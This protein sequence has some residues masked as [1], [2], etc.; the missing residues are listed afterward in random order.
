[1]RYILLKNK[2]M[3]PIH[4][5]EMIYYNISSFVAMRS[6][7]ISLKA[8]IFLYIL[9][10]LSVTSKSQCTNSTKFPSSNIQASIFN[11]LQTITTKQNAG[12]YFIIQGLAVGQTYQ[13]ESSNAGVYITVRDKDR[14]LL[15]GHGNTPFSYTVV[16]DDIVSVHINLV[17]PNCGS[18]NID[19]LTT[20]LCTTCPPAPP[21]IGI[22][23]STPKSSLDVNGKL[24]LNDNEDI[25]AEGMIRWNTAQQDFEG[26]DGSTWRSFTKSSASWGNLPQNKLTEKQK[27]ISSDGGTL[28]Y[29]G[30]RV[31]ISGD[32]AAIGAYGDD[33]GANMVQGSAYI[34]KRNGSSWTQMTKLTASDGATNDF[35]GASVSISGDYA[36]IGAYGDDIGVNTDQGS[37]YIF[38]RSGNSWTQEAKVTAFDG[39]S[40]DYFGGSVSISGDYVI[41]GAEGNTNIGAAYIFKRSGTSW[42]QEAKLAASD[43]A[44][45]HYFGVSISMAGDYTVIGATGYDLQKGA[46]YIFKRNG[47]S[48]TQ[49]AKLIAPDGAVGDY[50][51]NSVSISGD[52]V[53]ISASGDNIGVNMDQGSAYI[54]KRNGIFWS[55]EAKLTA[56]DGAEGDYFG[57]SASISGDYAVIGAYGDDVANV[58][59]G[60]AYIFRR[61]GSSWSQETKLTASDG[62]AYDYFGNSVFISGDY[63]VIGATRDNVGANNS[64]GSVYF[65]NR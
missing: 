2:Q 16:G 50:F 55:T 25:P 11:Q 35:F 37:A 36:A 19:R 39:S 30:A 28:D 7:F 24:K 52:Y 33:I 26:Y 58:Y 6:W 46:A 31:S 8:V 14:L 43:G 17:T 15:L 9:T 54:F 13:F 4:F 64:Q 21:N 61:I 47:T 34:F 1:M 44:S 60:S 57:F 20:S 27:G 12:Q 32:Y 51:G 53:V 45:N 56:P 48:W 63:V 38:K 3:K 42:T 23:I 29:F 41:I 10:C 22:G 49:E 18:E 65:F 62:E 5:R 59:Q 40:F